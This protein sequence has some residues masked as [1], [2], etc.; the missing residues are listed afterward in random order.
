[1]SSGMSEEGWQDSDVVGD[2]TFGWSMTLKRFSKMFQVLK[3]LLPCLVILIFVEMGKAVH[4]YTSRENSILVLS[5]AICNDMP[6]YSNLSSV[7]RNTVIHILFLYLDHI[8]ILCTYNVTIL[9]ACWIETSIDAVLTKFNIIP[10]RVVAF[11]AHTVFLNLSLFKFNWK[12]AWSSI[13]CSLHEVYNE[14]TRAGNVHI[15]D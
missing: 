5:S 2:I 14:T 3:E 12:F 1:M 4:V 6:C 15:V 11:Q 13:L 8:C 10:V 9:T 7:H